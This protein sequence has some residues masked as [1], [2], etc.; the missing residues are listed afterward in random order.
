MLVVYFLYPTHLVSVYA[1]LQ[2]LCV[3]VGTC[4]F[5]VF[6]HVFLCVCARVFISM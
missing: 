3:S 5:A 6:V 4:D 2:S 1:G